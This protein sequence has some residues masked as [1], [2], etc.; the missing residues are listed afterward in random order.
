MK[1]PAQPQ[2]SL[3]AIK[4]QLA[5]SSAVAPAAGC[6]QVLPSRLLAGAYPGHA[7]PAE[8]EAR[9]HALVDAGVRL[10]VNLMEEDET[11]STGQAFADYAAIA[12]ARSSSVRMVRHAIRD[13]SV[14]TREQMTIILDVIDEALTAETPV[15]IHC[16][17]GIGRTGTV[18]GCWL[19]RHRLAA[20]DNVLE[21][22]QRLRQQHHERRDRPSPETE[23]QRRFVRQWLEIG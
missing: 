14:P 17:G 1:S 4:L 5:D 18:V 15:Y 13:L 16:W 23:E 2:W 9:I 11:N 7:S 10:F 21:V 20:P 22:L 8:H 3:T 6:Y 12:A 19:Q